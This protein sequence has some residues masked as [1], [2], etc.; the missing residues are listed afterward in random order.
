M[1]IPITGLDIFDSLDFG[2][3]RL[4]SADKTYPQGWMGKTHVYRFH[5]SEYILTSI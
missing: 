2:Y 1:C 5:I 4:N 3:G